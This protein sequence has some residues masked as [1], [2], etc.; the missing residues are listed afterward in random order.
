MIHHKILC[1]YDPSAIKK[2]PKKQQL[3]D[4]MGAKLHKIFMSVQEK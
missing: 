2:N 4:Q 3:S 1:D